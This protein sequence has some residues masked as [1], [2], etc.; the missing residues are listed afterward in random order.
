MTWDVKYLYD[1][2][3][4]M[5]LT[6]KVGRCSGAAAGAR[7][8]PPARRGAAGCAVLI[9]GSMRPSHARAGPPWTLGRAPP[10]PARPWRRA[11]GCRRQQYVLLIT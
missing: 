10:A 9:A 5:C 2:E 8:P 11:L 7:A 1:G 6:L 4:S 3:C